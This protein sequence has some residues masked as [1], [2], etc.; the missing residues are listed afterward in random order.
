MGKNKK[1]QE[2]RSYQSEYRTRLEVID[3]V[4][5]YYIKFFSVVVLV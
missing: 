1:L 3:D 4:V 5:R 2:V